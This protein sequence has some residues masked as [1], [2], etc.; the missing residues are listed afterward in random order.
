MVE[1]FCFYDPRLFYSAFL[2]NMR[3][4]IVLCLLRFK[5]V[6]IYVLTIVKC[7]STAHLLELCARIFMFPPRN[8]NFAIVFLILY[9]VLW[10]F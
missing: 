4:G 10:L 9:T 1:T 2:A 5:E 7:F 3:S 6:E 8:V